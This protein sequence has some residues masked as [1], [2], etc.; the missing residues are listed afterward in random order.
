MIIENVYRKDE[1][2][3]KQYA[4]DLEARKRDVFR[5]SAAGQCP[6]RLS[7]QY[8]KIPG[9]PMSPRGIR[10]LRDG[11]YRDMRLK[12]EMEKLFPNNISFADS[13]V[14]VDNVLLKLDE[15]IEL[16]GHIDHLFYDGSKYYIVEYKGMSDKSFERAMRGEID[17]VYQVQALLYSIALNVPDVLFIAERKET[18]HLVEIHFSQENDA[19]IQ[20]YFDDSITIV[21]QRLD[22]SLLDEVRENYRR[23]IKIKEIAEA[24]FLFPEPINHLVCD[25]CGGIGKKN[26][27]NGERKC[28]ICG[29]LGYHTG[30]IKLKYPCSYCPFVQYCYN[31]EL[32][33][34]KW[35]LKQEISS[36]QVSTN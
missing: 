15:K 20:T 4:S 35:F 21:K 36:S 28:N 14:K 2:E 10:V 5:I 27:K 6:R 19:E 9:M 33:N 16:T 25:N 26:Y 31:A 3:A 34:G 22:M 11:T 12:E 30:E 8:L 17:K 29:G 7:Y 18:Q 24:K 23:I 32:K 13:S 1:E